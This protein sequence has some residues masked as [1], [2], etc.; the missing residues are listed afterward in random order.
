MVPDKERLSLAARAEMSATASQI[1]PADRFT[2]DAA[3]LPATRIDSML[4]L[5]KPFHSVRIHIIGNRRTTQF[6]GLHEN[7]S[8]S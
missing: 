8:Q 4:E 1:D 7:L 2:T 6:N 5:K 3:R